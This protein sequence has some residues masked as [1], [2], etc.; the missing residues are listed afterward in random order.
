MN[1]LQ[2]AQRVLISQGK[3]KLLAETTLKDYQSRLAALCDSD[4]KVSPDAPAAFLAIW[5]EHCEA[6]KA[7]DETTDE[8]EDKPAEITTD[9][10]SD[11]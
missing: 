7:T 8:A 11:E 4:G 9:D 2:K 5:S 6:M 1:Q 10:T 3:S